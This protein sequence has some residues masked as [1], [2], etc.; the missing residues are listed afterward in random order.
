MNV[1]VQVFVWT[2]VSSFLFLILNL[3]FFFFKIYL[4]YLFY[5]WLRWGFVAA[6][7]LSLVEASRGYS[8]LWCTGF[9]LRWLLL[10]RSVGSRC[11]GFG[12][13]GSWTLEHRL[14]SC[15]AQA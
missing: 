15:G 9:S 4:F 11:A 2:Y 14:S 3:L 10:L 13:C 5:F 7:G 12:S 8:L 1:H 6:H